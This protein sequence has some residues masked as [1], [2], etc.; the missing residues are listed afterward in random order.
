MPQ[1]K[2][3][4]PV[5]VDAFQRRDLFPGQATG[6]SGPSVRAQLAVRSLA[7]GFSHGGQGHALFLKKSCRVL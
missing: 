5:P 6:F 1:R 4:A 7:S 3:F 2:P